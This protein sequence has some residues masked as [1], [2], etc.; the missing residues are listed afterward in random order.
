MVD[1]R[2]KRVRKQPAGAGFKMTRSFFAPANS[3]AAWTVSKGVSSWV[4]ESPSVEC[5]AAFRTSAGGKRGIGSGGDG[6]AVLPFRATKMRGH[7]CRSNVVPKNIITGDNG[8]EKPLRSPARRIIVPHAGDKHDP[9]PGPRGADG[10][11]GAL[12]A[13][14][15]G[16]SAPKDGLAWLGQVLH[17]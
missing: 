14:G 5:E 17:F 4:R 8:P 6:D 11:F 16:K 2:Q 12:P 7:A 10:W 15:Q 9:A 1:F 13:R 3:A